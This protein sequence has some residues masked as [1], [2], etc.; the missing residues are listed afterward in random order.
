M[1]CLLK[2]KDIQNEQYKKVFEN[3]I[4]PVTEM[5]AVI[6]TSIFSYFAMNIFINSTLYIIYILYI[7]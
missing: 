2:A 3:T 5:R 7:L 6:I 1:Q 4:W